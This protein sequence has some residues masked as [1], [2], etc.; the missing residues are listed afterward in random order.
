[1]NLSKNDKKGLAIFAV[2]FVIA[3]AIFIGPMFIDKP[4]FDE[5]TLC[6]VDSPY[7][8]TVFLVD[9]TDNLDGREQRNLLGELENVK[10]SLAEFER[11]SIYLIS[12]DIGGLSDPLFDT[13]RP[14]T[15]DNA[16]KF[17]V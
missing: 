17:V 13:C 7:P 10:D 11:S 2:V 1:M 12:E 9:T 16:N 4:K 15:G 6:P 8:Q 5:E 14:P 3:I